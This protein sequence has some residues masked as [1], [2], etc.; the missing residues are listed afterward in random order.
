[1]YI[2]ICPYMSI[3]YIYICMC[4]CIYIYIYIYIFIYI[5]IYMYMCVYIYIYIYCAPKAP[6]TAPP[7]CN[8]T[9]RAQTDKER[10]RFEPRGGRTSGGGSFDGHECADISGVHMGEGTQENSEGFVTRETGH[11]HNTRQ[12]LCE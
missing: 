1:M 7:G 4:V 10:L 5:Y 8:K 3:L 12:Q 2:Y 6:Y 9:H 11:T